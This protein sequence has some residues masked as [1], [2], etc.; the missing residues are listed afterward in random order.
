MNIEKI[1]EYFS[2][3]RLTACYSADCARCGK[4]F[5][6]KCKTQQ[7]CSQSCSR[8]TGEFIPCAVCE[9]PTWI[10]KRLAKR[11]R[12][13]SKPCQWKSRR[14]EKVVVPCCFCGKNVSKYKSRINE[15]KKHFCSRDCVR[16]Y[17]TKNR[18]PLWSGGSYVSKSGYRYVRLGYRGPQFLEHRLVMERHLGRE[19]QNF[20]HVHH[21]NG[22]RSDN[23][24][25]NLELWAK[26][27]QP[28]GQRVDDLLAFVVMNYRD[29]IRSLLK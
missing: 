12:Y 26:L 6:T 11:K 8:K 20:E 24:I 19:L 13:C 4:L 21:K 17:V 23:S 22:I 2:K 14:K 9:K 15:S 5:F 27:S 28:Y 1:T 16:N 25:E 10:T 7:H 29:E 18:S 3:N